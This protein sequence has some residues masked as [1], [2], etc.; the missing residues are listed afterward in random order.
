MV[1]R[2]R[3]RSGVAAI[4]RL[5]GARRDE[6]A[7]SHC[8]WVDGRLTTWARSSSASH[9]A[10][11]WPMVECQAERASMVG[12]RGIDIAGGECCPAE[13]VQRG[14]DAFGVSDPLLHGHRFGGACVG[15]VDA[16]RREARAVSPARG[17][18]RRDADHPV[19]RAASSPASASVRRLRIALVDRSSGLEHAT[20]GEAPL[21]VGGAEGGD[22][23][24]A[25]ATS[26]WSRSP[27]AHSATASALRPQPVTTR[28]PDRRPRS[29]L[30]ASERLGPFEFAER[31]GEQR[32]A[33]HRLATHRGREVV[34]G[35]HLFQPAA[36]LGE[37][38]VERPEPAE[39]A[40]EPCRA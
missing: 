29:M 3:R 7:T 6:G 35:E 21:V 22:R 28:S 16:H 14:D 36:C 26:S 9:I 19:A 38:P 27:S 5:D 17:P 34:E 40:G 11:A 39:R 8:I 23:V 37:H 2:C 31:C 25:R 13:Q 15:G 32:E 20:Q 12:R 33:P 10:A 24:V 18:C 1:A 4:V 30:F